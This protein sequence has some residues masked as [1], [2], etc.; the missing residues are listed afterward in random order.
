MVVD[1]FLAHPSEIVE[2]GEEGHNW[3]SFCF[4]FSLHYKSHRIRLFLVSLK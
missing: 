3:D 2:K 1:E 4:Y